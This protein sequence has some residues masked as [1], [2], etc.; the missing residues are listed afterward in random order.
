MARQTPQEIT[1]RS[2]S[3]EAVNPEHGQI[4]ALAYH[5][6]QERGS[7]TDDDQR[8]WFRAEKQLRKAESVQRAA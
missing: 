6:W 3:T 4:E 1:T 2:G 8:D 5:L 7:P